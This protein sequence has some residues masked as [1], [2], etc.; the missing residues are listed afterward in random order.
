[1]KKYDYL[2][3]LRGFTEKEYTLF[4]TLS[5]NEDIVSE[6]LYKAVK[7]NVAGCATMFLQTGD[8]FKQWLCFYSPENECLSYLDTTIICHIYRHKSWVDE[9]KG[10]FNNL[11]DL[12]SFL[13]GSWK[14]KTRTLKSN[15]NQL[16]M[17]YQRYIRFLNTNAGQDFAYAKSLDSLTEENV[18]EEGLYYTDKPYWESEVYRM[19]QLLKFKKTIL[20]KKCKTTL[21]NLEMQIIWDL[22]FEGKKFNLKE[23]ERRVWKEVGENTIPHT[24]L[25]KHLKKLRL[26]MLQEIYNHLSDEFDYFSNKSFEIN[27]EIVTFKSAIE[28]FL[29]DAKIDLALEK[30]DCRET[31][32]KIVET[33]YAW[34]KRHGLVI[35]TAT[36]SPNILA[37]V[38][39]DSYGLPHHGWKT[40]FYKGGGFKD[41]YN[42]VTG[43]YKDLN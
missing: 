32:I 23:A 22:T 5:T 13:I 2:G 7:E 28:K 4:Y 26:V 12:L 33:A 11:N 14:N 6:E 39:G 31:N 16:D 10:D 35:S 36:S 43:F 15:L 34:A 18:F 19:Q 25:F 41:F 20:L 38:K 1:M 3:I 17:F 30:N 24:T 42:N 21:E 27:G 37:Q 40:Y 8:K 29:L 9:F